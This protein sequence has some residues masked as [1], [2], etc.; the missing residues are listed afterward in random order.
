MGAVLSAQLASG[1]LAAGFDP[2]AVSLSA[3]LDPLAGGASN[4]ALDGTL[5]S[6]LA[7]AIQ[8]VFWLA[9]GASLLGLAGTA[10]APG[11]RIAQLAARHGQAD[12][13]AAAQPVGVTEM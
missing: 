8:L 10:L 1:L 7:S 11:G 12:G 13:E 4:T 9:F 2:A 6:V 3:L 5:R